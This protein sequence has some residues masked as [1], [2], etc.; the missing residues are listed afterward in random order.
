MAGKPPWWWS[1]RSR[2]QAPL[3]ASAFYVKTPPAVPPEQTEDMDTFA[4]RFAWE[5]PSVPRGATYLP[6]PTPLP[7][8]FPWTPDGWRRQFDREVPPSLGPLLDAMDA[9]TSALR[10][11]R[12][13]LNAGKISPIAARQL[14]DQADQAH[15]AWMRRFLEGSFDGPD[16]SSTPDGGWPKS[17]PSS[18]VPPKP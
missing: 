8:T 11:I 7:G 15:R 2:P 5:I 4:K 13:G 14:R 12:D 1:T 3:P 10:A 9:Y 17:R 16:I 18:T 6:D